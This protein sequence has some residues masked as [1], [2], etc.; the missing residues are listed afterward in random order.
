MNKTCSLRNNEIKFILNKER[1]RKYRKK[2]K[3][4]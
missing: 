4:N 1:K 3:K 2:K